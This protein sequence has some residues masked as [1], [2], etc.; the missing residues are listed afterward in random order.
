M[1]T[2]LQGP[3]AVG[4]RLSANLTRLVVPGILQLFD[5]HDRDVEHEGNTTGLRVGSDDL[6]TD[7]LKVCSVV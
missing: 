2:R 6:D 3:N 5:V 1:T 4:V 7:A